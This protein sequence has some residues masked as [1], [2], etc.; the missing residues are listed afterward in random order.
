MIGWACQGRRALLTTALFILAGSIP[1]HAQAQATPSEDPL[2]ERLGGLPAISLVISDF[3]NDFIADEVILANP[4]VR[5]RKTPDTAPYIKFQ[6]T[7]LV[8][9]LAGGPCEYTGKDMAEAHGGLNVSAQEWDRMVEIFAQTLADHEVPEREQE[10][11]F[12]LLGPT[13][14]DIVTAED[15]Q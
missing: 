14:D 13:R 2:F 1:A 5:A 9:Q 15:R 12:G 6:V 8:C 3:V 11:L 10:E 7:T 4:A